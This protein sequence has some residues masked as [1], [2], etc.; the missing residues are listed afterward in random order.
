MNSLSQK[1]EASSK[2]QKNTN[3]EKFFYVDSYGF[4]QVVEAEN[5]IKASI[6]ILKSKNSR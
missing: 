1:E 3:L 4:I 6:L 2:Q 5:V